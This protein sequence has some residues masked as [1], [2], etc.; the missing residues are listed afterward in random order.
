MYTIL[1]WFL[2]S[3]R[4]VF[5]TKTFWSF[6]VLNVDLACVL[7]HS[8]KKEYW[9]W[10]WLWSPFL[11]DTCYSLSKMT[12]WVTLWHMHMESIFCVLLWK[13]KMESGFDFEH[14]CYY[15]DEWFLK[16]DLLINCI[17]EKDM[18]YF[19]QRHVVF[20]EKMYF[21]IAWHSFYACVGLSQK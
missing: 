8:M 3:T 18:V 14:T 7:S 20:W 9:I 11:S 15:R 21:R 10:F 19:H 6:K 2:I 1:I 4:I 17:L 13:M 12:F 16:V 5:S